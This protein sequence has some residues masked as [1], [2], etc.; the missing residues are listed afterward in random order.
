MIQNNHNLPDSDEKLNVSAL[1][2][3]FEKTTNSYKHLFFLGILEYLRDHNFYGN[4]I[5][6]DDIYYRMLSLAYAPYALFK[7]S[8]GTQDKIADYIDSDIISNN[9]LE[10]QIS[11]N[12]N[13]INRE[14]LLSIIRKEVTINHNLTRYVVFRLIRPFFSKEL[15]G[16]LDSQ[17]NKKIKI[18]SSEKFDPTRPLYKISED[19][20]RIIIHPDWMKYLLHNSK[21]IEGFSK[22]EWVKYMQSRNPNIPNI[23]SKAIIPEKRNALYIQKKVW[24]EILNM[25]R[26]KCIYS[27]E[28]ISPDNLALDHFLPWTFVAHD[29]MWNLVPTTKHVNS[30]KSNYIPNFDKYLDKF[31]DRQFQCLKVLHQD[32]PKLWKRIIEDYVV[33]LKMDNKSDTL[34]KENFMT[35]YKRTFNPYYDLAKSQ[36]FET[37]WEFE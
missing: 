12:I 33:D 16:L 28:I 9:S 2:R 37:G 24:K 21:I 14:R 25:H 8:F 19:E 17:V 7:L 36:G 15:R 23:A 27:N 32:D 29:R 13:L 10:H 34:V 31:I 18:L 4:I 30:A 11:D 5:Q 1:S 3:I 22:W 35:A 6:T 26:F 20:K